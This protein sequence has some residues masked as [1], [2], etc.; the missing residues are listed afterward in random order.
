MVGMRVVK[1]DDVEAALPCLALNA[2][3]FLG[4]DVI[5]VVGG[6]G[7]RVA[8]AYGGLHLIDAIE[9]VAEQH[10]AALMGIGLFAVLAQL[11]LD[12][13]TD[14]EPQLLLLGTLGRTSHHCSQKR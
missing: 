8:R 5:A 2:D 1:A 14:T 13:I 9:C 6:I 7:A 12:G 4:R 3:Q 10:A 11:A